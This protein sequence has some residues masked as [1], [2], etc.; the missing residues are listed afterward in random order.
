MFRDPHFTKG[1]RTTCEGFRVGYNSEV[2]RQLE[3]GYMQGKT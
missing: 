2:Q 1:Q 3:L